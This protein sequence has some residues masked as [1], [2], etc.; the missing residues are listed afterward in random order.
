ME[1]YGMGM[2]RLDRGS[3]IVQDRG[4]RICVPTYQ[5][6]PELDLGLA[7]P[8]VVRFGTVHFPGDVC[9][10]TGLDHLRMGWENVAVQGMEG[11]GCL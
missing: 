1:L 11:P 3:W 4:S 6:P 10:S 9:V 2:G 7:P 8:D 5:R